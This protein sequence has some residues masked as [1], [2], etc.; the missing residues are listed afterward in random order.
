MR[1]NKGTRGNGE[2]QGLFRS[3]LT[4]NVN[5]AAPAEPDE[6]DLNERLFE[7]MFARIQR[8]EEE[9][10]RR[11]KARF[12]EKAVNLAPWL[13]ANAVEQDTMPKTQKDR[14]KAIQSYEKTSGYNSEKIG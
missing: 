5:P 13:S 3:K 14:A 2:T 9:I 7:S 11:E 6:N 4:S 12:S 10:E 1:I 8:L